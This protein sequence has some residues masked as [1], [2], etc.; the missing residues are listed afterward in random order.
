MAAGRAEPAFC[1]G[2]H[3]F[4]VPMEMFQENRQK[5]CQSLRDNSKVPKGAVVILQS[6]IAETRNCSDNEPLFRQESYF[7]WTFGVEEPDCFGALDVD[8]G[9]AILFPPKLP[10]S[11]AVWMGKLLTEEEFRYRYGVDE[12]H[13]ADKIAQVLTG[14][15]PSVLLTLHGKNSDSGKY[16][17]EAVFEGIGQFKVNNQLLHPEITEC[18]VFKSDTEL[19]LLR[20]VNRISS[21]AHK[22]VMKNMQPGMYEY[23]A[24]SVFKNYCQ[25]M[26]GMRA[27][28]YTCICASGDNA[29]VL[30]YGHAGAPNSKQINDGDMCLF[31]M[32]G[33]YYCYGA[34]I[35]CSFPCNGKFTEKQRQVYET[36]YNA[37]RAVMEGCKPG[38][39]W[40]D[41]HKLAER[42][43]LEGLKK[44]GAVRGDIEAMMAVRLGAVFMPHGLGHF[45]GVD[46]HD[47]GGYPEGTER[48]TEPGL[49]SLRT[50]RTLQPRMV[51]TIEPGLYFIDVLL[52]AAFKNPQQSSF[53]VR[54]VI[55]SFRASGG[56]RIED[57]IIITETGMELMTDVPRTVEEIERIMIEGRGTQT[58][59]PQFQQKSQ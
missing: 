1:R 14:K 53:L 50:V 37:S 56:V 44:M 52:D 51:L 28:S 57:D 54:E 32:G 22:A 2:E 20:Y 29:S 23:Q 40:V 46:T 49:K 15:K 10:E 36:V 17:Q 38:V 33:E 39:C 9:K 45:M 31:D 16:S 5:L 30:H 47:V 42:V 4:K 41:M 24:E 19:A 58:P 13:F 43:T 35:T 12:V 18:R 7:H 3:T 55:D 6:G 21:E 59:L 48:H 26:G 25:Y 8:T 11:Y 27:Q 34:D